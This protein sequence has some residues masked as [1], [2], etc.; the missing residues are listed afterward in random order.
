MRGTELAYGAT[1]PPEQSAAGGAQRPIAYSSSRQGCVYRAT[2]MLRDGR[3]ELAYGAMR[4]TAA[5]VFRGT[6][7]ELSRETGVLPTLCSYAMLPFHAP[8]LGSYET[9]GTELATEVPYG[10]TQRRLVI[11][12]GCVDMLHKDKAHTRFPAV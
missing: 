3:T 5:G 6:A 12:K 8:M 10:A 4:C 2:K 9:D 7:R 11:R 1:R